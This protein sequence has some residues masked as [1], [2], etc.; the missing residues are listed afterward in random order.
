M[1]NLIPDH[2]SLVFCLG[3]RASTEQAITSSG[4]AAERNLR[5]LWRNSS[6]EKWLC[7]NGR[8][9]PGQAWPKHKEGHL[10]IQGG[11]HGGPQRNPV[12]RYIIKGLWGQQVEEGGW[13]RQ[14]WFAWGDRC[15][16]LSM[17]GAGEE[18][19]H[20]CLGP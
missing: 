13:G 8:E 16:A 17:T 10:G 3:L 1:C 15:P 6:E 12:H 4:R 19:P 14:L 11:S 9:L 5:G 7:C 2:Y 18:S 20:P